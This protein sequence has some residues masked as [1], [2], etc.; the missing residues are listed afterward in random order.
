MCGRYQLD[1]SIIDKFRSRFQIKGEIPDFKTS[2]NMAPG[3]NLP[4]IV[5]KG[6]NV[7]ELMQW[8]LIPFW[9]ERKENPTSLINIRSEKAISAHWAKHWMQTSRC[10]VPASGYYEWQKTK[11]GKIPYR[12][13][14]QCRE[15]VSFAGLYS[16]YQN[17]DT[18][19]EMKTYAILTTKP[20]KDVESI[21]NRM[22][23]I[24]SESEETGWLD[25]KNMDMDQLGKLLRP[26]QK[27][28]KSYEV[29]KIVN[30]LSNDGPELL[31]H[32]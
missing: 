25:N 21:H 4:V 29:D 27:K 23:V 14:E 9:E 11:N 26:Y 20:N 2:Y 31:K 30:N 5:S 8:G 18:G 13:Y 32:Y 1:L 22:P 15:Y 17:P 28:L 7:L 6:S 10:I 12:I 16:L 19:T 3:Q 24:L